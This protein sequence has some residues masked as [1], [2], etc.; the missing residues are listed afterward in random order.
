MCPGVAVQFNLHSVWD[1]WIGLDYAGIAAKLRAEFTDEDRAR[2]IP[3]T[4]DTEAVVAWANESSAIAE[5]P[6]VQYC[7]QRG[8]AC[9]YSA[10]QQQYRGGPKTVV[11]VDDAYLTAQASVVSD[12]IKMAGIRLGAILN[13]ALTPG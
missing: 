3:Q 13:I 12:R 7:I 10:D 1:N 6:D 11:A 5:R 4:T 2:W 9:W 8:D